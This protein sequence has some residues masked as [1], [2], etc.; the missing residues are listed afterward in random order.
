[1]GT[2]SEKEKLMNRR[3]ILW[4]LHQVVY[5]TR[6]ETQLMTVCQRVSPTLRTTRL[7]RVGRRVIRLLPLQAKT[8]PG[9]LFRKGVIKKRDRF[10]FLGRVSTL[11]P[12]LIIGYLLAGEEVSYA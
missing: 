10:G 8:L 3:K 7:P 6:R 9:V 2:V 12:S 11:S 4:V 5:W 1:M